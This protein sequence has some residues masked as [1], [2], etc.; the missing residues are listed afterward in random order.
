MDRGFTRLAASLPPLVD[1]ALRHRACDRGRLRLLRLVPPA[2]PVPQES[3][4]PTQAPTRSR[5]A[6]DPVGSSIDAT[7]RA[8]RQIEGPSPLRG[9]VE[10][11]SGSW[12]LRPRR[13][14][15]HG[16]RSLKERRPAP[17]SED[18]ASASTRSSSW[19]WPARHQRDPRVR[20]V[21][22]NRR[23][24]ASAPPAAAASPG[25][26]DPRPRLGHPRRVLQ[27]I[28]EEMRQSGWS[29]T[30]TAITRWGCP[31]EGDPRSQTSRRPRGQHGRHTARRERR[32]RGERVAKF[33][34]GGRRTTSAS[35][36]SPTQR[37]RPEDIQR[38]F[39]RTASGGLVRLRDIVSIEQKPTLQA[40]TRK[41][42]SAPSRS[43][44]TSAAR[45][46]MPTRLEKSQDIARRNLP[47]GYRVIP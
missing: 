39:V 42:R 38:L 47:D 46:P 44:P 23:S 4:V 34:E 3:F 26:D 32:D 24:R 25:V 20:T 16:L 13:E 10:G 6:S 29:P 45:P 21:R 40:I 1:P 36:S 37:Q 30:W 33:K 7:D 14:H 2:V 11:P 8:F 35:G 28:M 27:K 41:D 9:E 5:S 18:P 12:G 43:S 19:T 15:R 22:W 31:S 17:G